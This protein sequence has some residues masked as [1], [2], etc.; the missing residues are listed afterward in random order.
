MALTLTATGITGPGAVLA[1][2][3]GAARTGAST[4][5]PI[6]GRTVANFVTTGVGSAGA[7]NL[8]NGAPS[9]NLIADLT[10]YFTP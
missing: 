8:Y 10:G 5:N 4:L 1:Y 7:V 6:A 9:L 2:P 3:T